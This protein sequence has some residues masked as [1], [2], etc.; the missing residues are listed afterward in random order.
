MTTRFIY[1]VQTKALTEHIEDMTGQEVYERF[2]KW[3]Q[4]E[5]EDPFLKRLDVAAKEIREI[6]EGPI[7]YTRDE[8]EHFCLEELRETA[9][10]DFGLE[11]SEDIGEQ[12][13]IDLILDAQEE[14]DEKEHSD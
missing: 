11:V 5:P 10:D 2:E 8:I 3:M 12:E 4:G 6:P 13:L 7:P 1:G 9:E 14:Q